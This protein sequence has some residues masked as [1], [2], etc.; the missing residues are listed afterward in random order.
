[1]SIIKEKAQKTD[2]DKELD[3]I[4]VIELV[5]DKIEDHLHKTAIVEEILFRLPKVDEPL[6]GTPK[7]VQ[8]QL[9]K[10][11]IFIR[12]NPNKLIENQKKYDKIHLYMHGFLI[13]VALRQFPYIKGLQTVD[14]YQEA[15]IALRFKAI[16]GFRRGRGM[17]F[18]NFAKEFPTKTVLLIDT[19]DVKKG[20]LSAIRLE[21]K[22]DISDL[23]V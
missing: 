8:K 16:P 1:M 15:L 22:E 23:F 11:A 19:Y 20:A 14:I 21:K 5:D 2:V 13:N 3:D 7:E 9:D 17:S 6:V 10:L 4:A 18:L 12:R